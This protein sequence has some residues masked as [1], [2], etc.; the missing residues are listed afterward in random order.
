MNIESTLSVLTLTFWAGLGGP[1]P[2]AGGPKS[3]PKPSAG[4]SKS[5]PKPKL[6]FNGPKPKP[7]LSGPKPKPVAAKMSRLAVGGPK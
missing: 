3:G 4:D 2:S 7:G 1:K 5:G 6:G